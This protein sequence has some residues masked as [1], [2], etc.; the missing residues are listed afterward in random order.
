M[1]YNETL[2]CYEDELQ[3]L[4]ELV[5]PVIFH[6]DLMDGY[7]ALVEEEERQ[8]PLAWAKAITAA[9]MQSKEVSSFVAGSALAGINSL[10]L[11]DAIA[12]Y[13]ELIEDTV[14]WEAEGQM[15]DFVLSLKD[16]DRIYD[17]LGVAFFSIARSLSNSV[18]GAIEQPSS[19]GMFQMRLDHAYS[20]GNT[21][22][23]IKQ[24]QE[25]IKAFQGEDESWPL[26]IGQNSSLA[27]AHMVLLA[28]GSMIAQHR[29][30]YE[31]H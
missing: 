11:N 16:G 8:T 31:V 10:R 21:S 5:H 2:Q 17:W 6:P 28:R 25:D 15:T 19:F 29:P 30:P 7:L 12:C 1:S 3:T 18:F 27:V 26:A 24:L 4:L 23:L 9:C 14:P 20:T 22:A 13:E